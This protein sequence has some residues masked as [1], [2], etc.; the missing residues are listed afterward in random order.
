MNGEWTNMN[1][2]TTFHCAFTIGINLCQTIL[3]SI[4]LSLACQPLCLYILHWKHTMT[5][6]HENMFSFI[7][8]SLC[9]LLSFCALCTAC[10]F[11]SCALS[12][13]SLLMVFGGSDT[14]EYADAMCTYVQVHFTLCILIFLSLFVSIS[15]HC[16]CDCSQNIHKIIIC[17][18]VFWPSADSLKLKVL[19]LTSNEFEWFNRNDWIC[20]QC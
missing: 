9:V 5:V 8:C 13:S 3:S 7:L 20:N 2:N 6:T 11:F 17:N 19:M 16:C 10:W 18:I 14:L 12:V 1:S 4:H 15:H